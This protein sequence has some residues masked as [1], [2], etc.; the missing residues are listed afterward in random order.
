MAVTGTTF[1]AK[2]GTADTTELRAL[3]SQISAA[4]ASAG[5]VKTTDTGQINWATATWASGSQTWG[6]EIWRFNDSLQA[7]K[8]V[9]IKIVYSQLSSPLMLYMAAQIGT[10]TDGAGNL[11]SMAGTG[12]S[13]TALADACRG[14]TSANPATID[15]FYVYGDGSSLVLSSH[16][17]RMVAGSAGYGGLLFVERVRHTDGTPLGDGVCCFWM[18]GYNAS[19]TSQVVLMHNVYPQAG[20]I[21][22]GWFPAQSPQ[23]SSGIPG[24]D[25]F[26]VPWFTGFTPRLGAPSQMV[27]GF[28]RNDMTVGNTFTCNH[29]GASRTFVALTPPSPS[30][31]MG[32]MSSVTFAPAVRT[33]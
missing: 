14:G 24:A 33:T 6:Y 32:M 22:A 26:T 20:G 11:T 19:T 25:M 9:F 8:P 10:G 3:G 17:G 7:T 4:I 1:S 2:G 21:N 18:S 12:V 29:Y 28:C 5:M 27:V 31:S 15:Q 13:V 30:Y 16:P 23:P